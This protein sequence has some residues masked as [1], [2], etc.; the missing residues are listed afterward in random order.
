M[1]NFK[2]VISL[3]LALAMMLSSATVAFAAAPTTSQEKA[4]VLNA[5]GLFDGVN[6]D[7]F[8]ANITGTTN[9]EQAMKMIVE[10]LNWDVDLEAVSEF[11]DVAVWAQPYVAV[12]VD[13]EVTNGIGDGTMFGGTVEVT[14]RQ[15]QTWIDRALGAELAGSWAAN[16]GLNEDVSLD[17][18]DLVDAI[19]A[20]LMETPIGGTQSLIATICGTNVDLLAIATDAGLITDL[21]VVSVTATNLKEAVVVFNTT[22]VKDDAEDET[23]YTIDG[24]TIESAAVEADGK[25]VVLTLTNAGI[26]DNST[27]Y[28]L[29]VS[30]VLVETSI[31]FTVVDAA[32]PVAESI[33][34][35]GPNTFDITFSEP[36]DSGSAIA[37]EVANGVYGATPVGDDSNVV[38]VTLGV[39]SLDEDDYEVIVTGATDFANHMMLSK[40]FTLSYV[41]DTTIPVPV[42]VSADQTEVVIDFGKEVVDED[43]NPLDETYFYHS[44]S[45]YMPSDDANG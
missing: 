45:S 41:K 32:L 12:A 31:T 33:T 44:Y 24:A 8:D 4:V 23:N 38:E 30:D 1:R 40:T 17:R 2:K 37:V 20:A 18:G 16:A 36:I 35:T 3:V 14:S 34:L 7:T 19:F 6:V 26:F 13:M 9:R 25:T 21:A 11:T 15:L 28:T 39:S 29:E 22:V 42:L 5:L 27:E 43:G 10:A